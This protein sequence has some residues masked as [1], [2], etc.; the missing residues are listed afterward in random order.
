VNSLSEEN[1]EKLS[2]YTE[3]ILDQFVWHALPQTE[4]EIALKDMEVIPA[5]TG[6]ASVSVPPFTFVGIR[7][8]A[9]EGIAEQY[10]LEFGVQIYPLG[11]R[12]WHNEALEMKP[13][14]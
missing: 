4:S 2:K 6:F 8:V 14:A 7:S 13:N 3:G 5:L 9:K 11:T 12:I 10:F 1:I